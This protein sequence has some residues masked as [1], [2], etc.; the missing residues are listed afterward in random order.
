MR[1]Y[2]LNWMQVRDYLARDDRVVLPLGSVEQHGYSSLGTDAIL[3]ERVA[4]E[5]AEPLGIPVLPALPFG[6]TPY[7][8]NFPGTLSLRMST[9]IEV[10]KDLLDTLYHQ[11][12]RRFALINGHGGNAPA[13]GVVREWVAQRREHKVEVLLHNWWNAPDTLA[14][15]K[16]ISDEVAHGNWMENFPWTRVDSGPLPDPIPVGDLNLIQ[17][18]S[19]DELSALCPT[20]SFGGAYERSDDDMQRIWDAGVAEVRRVLDSGWLKGAL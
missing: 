12:F 1:L 7:F 14:T 19:A 5:A 15:V 3:A 2:D 18:L 6:M 11:G 10:I 8:V 13:T 4:V 17:R 9:Y 20:G 16:T